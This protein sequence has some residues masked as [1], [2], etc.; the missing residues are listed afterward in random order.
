MYLVIDTGTDASPVAA[1]MSPAANVPLI[2]GVVIAMLLLPIATV[3]TGFCVRACLRRKVQSKPEPVQLERKVV[4]N[5]S[6]P[7]PVRA[8]PNIMTPSTV[9]R[10]LGR[11]LSYSNVQSDSGTPYEELQSLTTISL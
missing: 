8:Q 11:S 9:K 6:N 2:V 10:T 3:T 4:S 5:Q 7:E 1:D